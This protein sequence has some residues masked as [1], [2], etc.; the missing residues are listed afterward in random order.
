[1]ADAGGE[2]ELFVP[3]RLCLF[4]EHSDWA[5]QYGVHRGFC[6]VIGTDQGLAAVATPDEAFTVETE[7]PDSLGRPSGR[8]RQMSC[9][10]SAET[11][12]EAA[13]DEG[14]FFRYCAGVAYEMFEK[15]GISGGI[16][17]RI[18]SM[19][20]PLRKGVSSSAAV[21]ILMAKAFDEVY[22]LGLFPHELMEVAYLGERLTGS[23]CGRMDQACIYGKTPV[24]LTFQKSAEIRVE[25][26]F[27]G[28]DVP[29]FFV[30]LAGKKDTVRILADLQGAYLG[31]QGVQRGLGPESER[32]VR[33]AYRALGDGDAEWLGRLMTEAQASFDRMVAPAS[34]EELASPLLHELLGF[35][36]IA[37]HVYGG[38]GVGSQGDGTAQFVARSAADRDEAMAKIHDA[39]G[40]MQCFPLTVLAANRRKG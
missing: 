3:G 38:K 4:G 6:L 9:R 20:L 35:D 10:W 24:L 40:D 13:K 8:R 5:A 22:Q 30:D 21:C 25:P 28:A 39:F 1:M 7:L 14:E 16:N 34:P 26:V 32:I 36:G 27:P 11:L 37:P 17:L 15:P 12:L 2:K 31:N 23:Q 29:M 33:E 19:D 18:T